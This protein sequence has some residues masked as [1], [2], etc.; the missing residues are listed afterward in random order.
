[1]KEVLY[2]FIYNNEAFWE[3]FLVLQCISLVLIIGAVIYAVLSIY[4][5]YKKGERTIKEYEEKQNR[6][7]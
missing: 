5:D 6:G 7:I 1:M 3:R 2:N 4:M